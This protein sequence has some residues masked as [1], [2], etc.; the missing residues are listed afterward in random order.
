MAKKSVNYNK[1]TE[2]LSTELAVSYG[3]T[4][5]ERENVLREMRKMRLSQKVL[6]QKLRDR[7]GYK[8][9]TNEDQKAFLHWLDDE[10]AKATAR[11][12]E[13]YP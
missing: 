11:R 2:Q 13:K 10:T 6:L 12:S 5:E 1:S 4:P 8:T 7:Y 3:L 9:E